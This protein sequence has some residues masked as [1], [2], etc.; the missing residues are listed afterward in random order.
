MA[1]ESYIKEYLN[2]SKKKRKKSE[3]NIV[4]EN[5]SNENNQ[6]CDNEGKRKSK[7]IKT[8]KYELENHEKT[9]HDASHTIKKKKEMYMDLKLSSLDCGGNGKKI[10]NKEKH[11]KNNS[12][13]RYSDKYTQECDNEGKRKSQKR[14]RKKNE[15]ENQEKIICDESQIELTNE[16]YMDVKSSLDFGVNDKKIKSKT[17]HIKDNLDK[18][19]S[20]ENS[21]KIN[22]NISSFIPTKV[23]KDKDKKKKKKK[24][25]LR[26]K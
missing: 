8:K 17:K 11:I 15:S 23:L 1:F 24:K 21:Q 20:E 7:K 4:Y 16:M 5:F 2:V 18:N 19:Y 3:G 22:N 26:K 14:K 9:I 13:I 6:E 12:D 25:D 10:K